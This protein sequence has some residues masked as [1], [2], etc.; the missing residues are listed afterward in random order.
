MIMNKMRTITRILLIKMIAA[1]LV[2]SGIA[3]AQ[4]GIVATVNNNPIT[5]YDVEQR[6]R[7]LEFATN[8]Q[9]TDKNRDRVYEDALQL[10][11]DDKLRLAEAKD[12]IPDV[13]SAVLPEA[14]NFMNQNFCLLYTSP[15]PRDRG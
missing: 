9:I 14:R 11:I 6:A 7:F 1:M 5:N 10:I 15:S 8:I 3:A 4:I 2:W 12:L 13:E